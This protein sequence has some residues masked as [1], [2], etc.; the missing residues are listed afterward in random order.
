[1]S[2]VKEYFQVIYY[3]FINY[4]DFIKHKDKLYEIFEYAKPKFKSSMTLETIN[5]DKSTDKTIFIVNLEQK[6]SIRI[7]KINYLIFF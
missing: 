2:F 3:N 1:M 5:A 7:V 6:N 4:L